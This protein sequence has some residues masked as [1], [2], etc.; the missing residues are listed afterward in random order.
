MEGGERVLPTN[1][2]DAVLNAIPFTGMQGKVQQDRVTKKK[3]LLDPNIEAMKFWLGLSMKEIDPA[4]YSKERQ[5]KLKA[6]ITAISDA[7]DIP[8][9]NKAVDRLEDIDPAKLATLANQIKAK[10]LRLDNQSADIVEGIMAKERVKQSVSEGM[11][12]P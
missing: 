12:S 3:V 9:L 2:T 8:S 7:K 5:G 10:S 11:Q 6:A 1:F 4:R